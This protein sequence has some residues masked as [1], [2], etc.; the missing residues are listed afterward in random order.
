M[1]AWTGGLHI[2][3]L[4]R[5]QTPIVDHLCTACGMHK[6]VTGRTKATEFLRA[7]PITEHRAVC[8]PTNAT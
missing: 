1:S 2:R 7:N 4:D 5:D 6:R 8:R 3:G